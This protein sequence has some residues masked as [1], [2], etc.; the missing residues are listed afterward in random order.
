M[1]KS[2]NQSGLKPG[3]SCINQLLSITHDTYKSFDC[4][5]EVRGVFPDISKA[6]DKVWRN[7]IIFEL[8]QN[9]ISGKL[10]KFLHDFLVNRKHGVVL[11]WKVS[12][13]ANVKAGVRQG[14]ILGPLL[15][16]IYINDL[17]KS[18]SSN[19]KLFVTTHYFP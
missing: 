17:T 4:G 7:G 15:F 8:K 9:S 11:N 10:H 6:F 12:F 18:L 14:S 2:P 19:A 3:D 1:F 16:L 5:Y 13:W